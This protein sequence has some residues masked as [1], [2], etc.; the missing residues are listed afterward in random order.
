[1]HFRDVKS[2]YEPSRHSFYAELNDWFGF[3]RSGDRE[4]SIVSQPWITYVKAKVHEQASG[5]R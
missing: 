5:N 2:L 1:M 3:L 4:R